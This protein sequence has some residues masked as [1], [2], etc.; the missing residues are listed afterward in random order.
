MFQLMEKK[1]MMMCNGFYAVKPR[2]PKVKS[3]KKFNNVTKIVDAY[4]TIQRHK[5]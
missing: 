1:Y 5:R 4:I 3:G 2:Q